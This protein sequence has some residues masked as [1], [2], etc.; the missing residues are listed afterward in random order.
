[1]AAGH[2][3]ETWEVLVSFQDAVKTCFSKYVDFNGRARRSEFWWWVLFTFVLG[4]VASIV[5]A[6]LGTRNSSGS[7][8]FQGIAN[9]AV[10]LPSLAVGARR[11]HDTGRSAW[12]LL[13]WLLCIIGWIILIV[14]FCQDSHGDN[15]YGPSPKG[16]GFAG[17]PGGPPSP[18]GQPPNPYGQPPNPYGQPPGNP[19][20]PNPYGDQ[21]PPPPNPYGDP[22]S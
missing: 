5:D 12:W 13:L 8:L 9:L 1:V 7:G 22:P 3:G 2:I 11:L 16:L 20:P 18:Y 14:W 17:G 4:I 15:K 21:P 19:P 6:I 10:L